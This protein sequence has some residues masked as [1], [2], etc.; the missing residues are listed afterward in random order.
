MLKISETDVDLT[1]IS[2]DAEFYRG[3]R[4]Q[5]EDNIRYYNLT[6]PEVSR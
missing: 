2:G 4:V 3:D 1:A 6:R 5:V